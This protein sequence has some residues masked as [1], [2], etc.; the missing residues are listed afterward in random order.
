SF[1][2]GLN[3]DLRCRVREGL[4]NFMQSSYPQFL[5]RTRADIS[6]EGEHVDFVAPL[7]RSLADDKDGA[8]GTI[9]PPVSRGTANTE[10]DPVASRGERHGPDASANSA[11]STAPSA[12]GG[13][14]A[15]PAERR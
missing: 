3:W 2:S 12:P 8:A 10:A 15:K 1:D 11:A 7:E 14:A 9:R 6:P 4:L 5:P 13:R